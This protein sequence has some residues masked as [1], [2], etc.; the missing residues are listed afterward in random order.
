MERS[1]HQEKKAQ[2]VLDEEEEEA[3]G[4]V[5]LRDDKVKGVGEEADKSEA[6]DQHRG[7]LVGWWRERGT[8]KAERGGEEEEERADAGRQDEGGTEGDVVEEVV[9][10]GLDRAHRQLLLPRCSDRHHLFPQASVNVV[11]HLHA[12]NLR[13]KNLKALDSFLD[14]D[15]C[16]VDVSCIFSAHCSSWDRSDVFLLFAVGQFLSNF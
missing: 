7:R 6:G 16:G 12:K 9:E 13:E 2:D 8:A 11:Q 15:D 1:K 14:K 4:D 10:A 5:D 3:V